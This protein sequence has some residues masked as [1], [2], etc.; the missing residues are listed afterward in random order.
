MLMVL[1]TSCT[2]LT[3]DLVPNTPN[4]TELVSGID[5]NTGD[6]LDGNGTNNPDNGDTGGDGDG[7]GSG[8]GN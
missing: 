5:S 2:D 8:K 6:P 3:E 4:T 1:T 7:D